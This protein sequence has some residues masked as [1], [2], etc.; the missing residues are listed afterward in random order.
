[1][2]RALWPIGAADELQAPPAVQLERINHFPDRPPRR[3]QNRNGIRFDVEER[4]EKKRK[5]ESLSHKFTPR[6]IRHRGAAGTRTPINQLPTNGE[7]Q[8]GCPSQLSDGAEP[9]SGPPRSGV[10]VDRGEPAPNPSGADVIKPPRPPTIATMSD[11]AYLFMGGPW[12]ERFIDVPP[13]KVSRAEP[14]GAAYPIVKFDECTRFAVYDQTVFAAPHFGP[15]LVY[16]CRGEPEPDPGRVAELLE[17]HLIGRGWDG[18]P[19]I[20]Q[21]RHP[22]T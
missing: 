8:T 13:A 18:R 20:P 22:P 10:G 2:Q 5:A 6:R 17:R 15:Q 16:T 19:P 3:N 21:E 12:H 4:R 1:V 7:P 11:D 14:I 9:R